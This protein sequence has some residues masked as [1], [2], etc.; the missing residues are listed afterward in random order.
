MLGNR[1]GT[2]NMKDTMLPLMISMPFRSS[3]KSIACGSYH[4][5]VLNDMG[6]LYTWGCNTSGQLGL[7]HYND[8]VVPTLVVAWG[9]S[10]S[11]IN[12]VNC[13]ATSSAVVDDNGTT[14]TWGSGE[15]GQLGHNDL[16]NRNIPTVVQDLQGTRIVRLAIG[17]A[18]ML[19]TSDDEFFV[20]G[21]NACGQLGLG[22]TED[23][24]RPSTLEVLGRQR[25]SSV[26][27]GAAHSV[28]IVWVQKVQARV[29]YA[30]GSNSSG[31]LGISDKKGIIMKPTV[32]TTNEDITD[33]SC[34][35]HHTVLLTVNGE[36]MSSGSNELGQL[37][38]GEIATDQNEFK[39]IESMRGRMV[40]AVCCGG[41][42][43]LMLV[44]R[45]W[46]A[47]SEAKDC[48]ACKSPFTMLNRR[49]H[50]R[51]CGGIFCNSCSS[52]K[53]AI[54]K[55]GVVEPVRVCGSCYTKITGQR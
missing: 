40:R 11:S 22:H 41:G 30:W 10:A 18:H 43:T 26:S 17:E 34:G 16:K 55:Y 54:L 48:M 42:N 6:Q 19:A 49:H 29:L 38:N 15:H 52:K 37:G 47:D 50:C 4:T 7:G 14:Y 53:A 9:E 2:G 23:V 21:W 32:V 31:Q 24:I 20:W 44:A 33:L 45:A 39:I 35:S 36:I 51:N 46:V 27:A 28:A 12:I 5:A 8:V 3:I 25:V 1:I 13:G